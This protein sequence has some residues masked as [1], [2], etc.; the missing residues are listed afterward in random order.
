M[1]KDYIVNQHDI[2]DCGACCLESIIKYYKGFIPLEKIR[3]DTKTDN[4]G[5]TAFNLITAAKKYG[6]N[7]M[8]KK[9]KE[10]KE[11]DISLPAIAHIITERG[12]N[13][14][15][16]IY[17]IKNNVVHIMDPAKG[18]I[19][20]NIETFKTKWTN[21]ILIFEPI[22]KIPLYENKN[23]LVSLFI[24]ILQQE[25]KL[26]YKLISTQ[27]IITILSIIISYYYKIS[28]SV[29][30]SSTINSLI[31]TI[32]IFFICNISKV[33][34]TYLK[35]EYCTYL[36]KNIDL[37]IIPDFISHILKLP[38]NIIKG[39][40]AGE[41]I[42]RINEL[43]N[44]KEL[45]SNI[46]VSFFLETALIISSSYFLY[47]INNTLFFLLCL[48]SIIY[49]IIGLI[50]NPVIYRKIN[51]NIDLGTEFNSEL[52]E[53]IDSIDS[54]KNL[55]IVDYIDNILQEKYTIYIKDTFHFS[56]FNNLITLLKNITYD[57]GLFI[58]NSY[59]IIL[60]SQNKISFLSLVTFNTLI[61]YF[62]EPIINLINLIPKINFLRLSLSKVNEF[63]NIK[64]E[65]EG[66]KQYFKT[67]DITFNNLSYSYNDYNQI[68]NNI[69]IHIKN[70][71]HI[72]LK[73]NSGCGKSTLC[74]ILSKNI[75]DYKGTIKIDNINIKDYSL[76]TIRNSIVYVSQREKIFTDTI[77]NNILLNKKI[78]IHELNHFLKISKVD[79]IINNKNFRLD[80]LILDSG[81]NLSGGELQ[82]IILA[83]ALVRKPK[84][85]ILDEALSEVDNITAS[86]ILSNLDKYL[87]NTTIIF[88][89]HNEELKFNNVITME[90]CNAK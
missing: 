9:M 33:Y 28:I 90:K 83:R 20:E 56:K 59:G 35:D 69:N 62:I 76:N 31:F 11:N 14:F 60:V 42:T 54:I 7:A 1:K 37:K 24:N 53:K 52:V 80:S 75:E 72:T 17:K 68:L 46:I 70:N 5:T 3:L 36:S 38:L 26:T 64:V 63:L 57:I 78:S 71:S 13:H 77:K 49:L 12:I 65:Q 50:T 10:I 55:N 25:N 58:I 15:V 85:L 30:E 74:K 82:R 32:I 43:N 8:G 39:R 45:F 89:S 23:H 88:I 18:Y 40:R 81:Y 4:N 21:I 73:G 51:D 34:I 44:I 6:F 16:V 84:I 47:S 29:I 27:V 86:T 61:S 22:K 87:K 41:I 67:G 79:E 48:K 19:K 66:E 2:R